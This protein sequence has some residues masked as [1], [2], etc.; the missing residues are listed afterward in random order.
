MGP[1]D[2]Q[3][4][5]EDDGVGEDDAPA[6][7]APPAPV[8]PPARPAAAPP[9]PAA[10]PAA[11]APAGGLF[12]DWAAPPPPRAAPP[13]GAA[14]FDFGVDEDAAEEDLDPFDPLDE[15]AL[16][17]PPEPPP[18]R[19]A[20][21]APAP[22]G[23]VPP[24]GAAVDFGLGEG[25]TT[26]SVASNVVVDTPRAAPAPSAPRAAAGSEK[27]GPTKVSDASVKAVGDVGPA[28]DALVKD[29]LR[30]KL[31]AQRPPP[32]ARTLARV[33]SRGWERPNVCF[34]G[35]LYKRFGVEDPWDP[36]DTGGPRDMGLGPVA[37]KLGEQ[38]REVAPHLKIK[39]PNAKPKASASGGA[40]PADDPVARFRRPPTPPSAPSPA[41]TPT[42]PP[43]PPPAPAAAAAPAPG[44]PPA[45]PKP[46]E[47]GALAR[48]F[49]GRAEKAGL[50]GKL[51]V[52]PD[53]AAAAK[54]PAPGAATSKAGPPGPPPAGTTRAIA[55]GEKVSSRP[56]SKA[57]PKPA[58]ER[59]ALLG[60]LPM[61]PD[62]AGAAGGASEAPT[63]GGGGGG[64]RAQPSG[65][66]PMVRPRAAAP[67]AGPM[68]DFGE[69]E[70]IELAQV[71]PE[72]PPSPAP[73][74][75]L[76]APDEP[77]RPA[78]KGPTVDRRPPGKPV[79]LDD[80]FGSGQEEGRM[81]MRRRPPP[82]PVVVSGDEPAPP[83]A[84]RA[85]APLPKPAPP[86]KPGGEG[87][88]G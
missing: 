14:R 79:G 67:A 59:P 39:D 64:P 82:A 21:E 6:L 41:P 80:L 15:E 26:S 1:R 34:K 23:P 66:P 60:K 87:A 8:A 69:P 18:L 62:A 44:G 56:V 27:S 17:L 4:G 77:A 73:T 29:L 85:P 30:K 10:A 65:R 70:V 13:A 63:G 81:S 75:F 52:R 57:P 38:K 28:D 50:V 54:P 43:A 51:P 35:R 86:P 72:G 16:D 40:A 48:E 49:G 19:P 33:G 76:D 58:V 12:D 25:P 3:L 36:A 68:V 11:P 74:R 78:A 37:L 61:R 32:G 83:T 9:A 71:A 20:V 42:P 47:A 7:E 46:S 24:A 31:L 53:L 45:A 5:F 2:I 55:P 22:R 84:P 88:G